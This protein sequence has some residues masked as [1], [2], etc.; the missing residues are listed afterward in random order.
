[1]KD[2]TDR[3]QYTVSCERLCKLRITHIA[4]VVEATATAA[5]VRSQLLGMAAVACVWAWEHSGGKQWGLRCGLYHC[6]T[7]H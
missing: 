2:A 6:E 7:W 4:N 3:S 5:W 1:V